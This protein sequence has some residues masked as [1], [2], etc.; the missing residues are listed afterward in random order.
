MVFRDSQ[1]SNVIGFDYQRMSRRRGAGL[2]G[3]LRRI[4]DVRET[5]FPGRD[6]TRGEN[7]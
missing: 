1:L 6:R 4:R 7:A 5:A 2:I 3:R